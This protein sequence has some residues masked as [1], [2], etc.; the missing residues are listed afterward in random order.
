LR[1]TSD[2]SH[3]VG[4]D[5]CLQIERSESGAHRGGSLDVPPM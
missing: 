1:E 5:A 4:D 3:G 2:A